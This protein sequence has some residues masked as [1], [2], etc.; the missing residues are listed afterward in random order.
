MGLKVARGKL[1][2]HQF[3]LIPVKGVRASK[4]MKVG[5]SFHRRFY[6]LL[7]LWDVSRGAFDSNSPIIVSHS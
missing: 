7:K 2:N 4:P 1:M 5:L 6:P 3:K